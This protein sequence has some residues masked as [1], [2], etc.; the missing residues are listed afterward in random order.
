MK[1]YETVS[2]I[3]KDRFCVG[4]SKRFDIKTADIELILKKCGDDRFEKI[5]T[6][7][8]AAYAQ[9]ESGMPVT[10]A[11]IAVEKKLRKQWHNTQTLTPLQALFS[12]RSALWDER[13]GL[14]LDYLCLHRTC[15][16]LLRKVK[17]RLDPELN[18]ICGG[19]EY[20][21][22]ES[23]L[24]CFVGYI[25]STAVKEEA[26]LPGFFK[27]NRADLFTNG[28]LQEAAGVLEGFLVKG[29]GGIVLK[30]MK[31]WLVVSAD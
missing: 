16:D 12:L 11:S 24:P 2:E 17:E 23:D 22:T 26:G 20:L 8:R 27:E 1:Q 3:F 6:E 5:T 25:L 19:A 21:R 30:I 29:A 15:W 10:D 4:G 14:N 18:R 31:D 13:V 9:R 7:A 28:L